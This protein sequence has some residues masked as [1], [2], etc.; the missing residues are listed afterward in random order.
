M[1]YW[2]HLL[3]IE[4]QKWNPLPDSLDSCGEVEQKSPEHAVSSPGK[5]FEQQGVLLPKSAETLEA[6][7]G[8]LG[9]LKHPT[10]DSATH[11]DYIV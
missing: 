7:V 9:I 5:R 6:A 1:V 10:S 2:S 4:S 11:D 8:S 3:Q